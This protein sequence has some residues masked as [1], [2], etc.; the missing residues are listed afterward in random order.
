M[1][2]AVEERGGL[3]PEGRDDAGMFIVDTR[4]V[5]Q[6]ATGH[7]TDQVNMSQL[8]AVESVNR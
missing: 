7:C 5:G 6:A 8:L 3:G 4:R 1:P 2:D